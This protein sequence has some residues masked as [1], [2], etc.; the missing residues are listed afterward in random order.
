V[1]A[2]AFLALG[3]AAYG[4]ISLY[5]A[6]V[7]T[8]PR[9]RM[10]SFDPRGIVAGAQEWSAR[11][12]DGLTLR[13]WH[14]PTQERRRLIIVVHGLWDNVD[15]VAGPALDLQRRG[16]DV[17]LFDLRGHGRSDWARLSMGRR[18]RR[19]LRAAL[20]WARAEG[21]APERIGWL[22]YSLAGSTLLMEAEENDEIWAAVVDSPFGNLPE[23]LDSQLSVQSGLPSVF[24]P[25]ILLAAHLAFDSPSSD[26]IPE[27]SARLWGE[28]PLLLIHGTADPI[29]PVE[30][31]QAV[32]R[33]AGAACEAVYLPDTGHCD[34]YDCDPG[35]Y[36]DRI[37]AFFRRH[38]GR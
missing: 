23:V 1:V 13:G 38:L 36:V 27:R 35:G 11:T 18:E 17:L 30:Q 34:A 10:E 25:G 31:G 22:G 28:R 24:N 21:F 26:L 32:A 2:L 20:E 3:F 9:P 12:E 8:S 5:A 29:V 16:Y 19:D 6:H 33:A 4:G 37:D 15:H 14:L 7:L